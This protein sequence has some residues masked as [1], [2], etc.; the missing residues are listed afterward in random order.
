MK[1]T[2]YHGVAQIM[3][4]VTWTETC[5]M[6]LQLC[7]HRQIGKRP[8]SHTVYQ[9]NSQL[10]GSV[11]NWAKNELILS[12]RSSFVIFNSLKQA[13]S[14]R[15]S[16][17]LFV[18][19]TKVDFVCSFEKLHRRLRVWTWL[20]WNRHGNRNICSAEMLPTVDHHPQLLPVTSFHWI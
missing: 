18:R 4:D 8:K 11:K 2:P 12:L 7:L 14:R 1:L 10:Y 5:K 17:I 13:F 19:S 16:S 20:Y 6:F 3:P 9:I 15:S